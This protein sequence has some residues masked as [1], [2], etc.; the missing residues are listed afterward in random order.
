MGKVLDVPYL[1]SAQ[2]YT[3][4]LSNLVFLGGFFISHSGYKRASR[5]Q[6]KEAVFDIMIVGSDALT[7]VNRRLEVNLVVS[8]IP[9]IRSQR[10]LQSFLE[11]DPSLIDS[12]LCCLICLSKWKT[13][14]GARR[15][16]C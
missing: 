11:S 2:H 7:K 8:R 3:I 4:P 15:V 13:A 10:P 14:T 16:T 5:G 12:R 9:M 6:A 1:C